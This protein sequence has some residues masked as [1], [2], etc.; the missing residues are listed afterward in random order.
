M[1][2]MKRIVPALLAAFLLTLTS[3]SGYYAYHYWR[4]TQRIEAMHARMALE[5]KP[6]LKYLVVEGCNPEGHDPTQR[7]HVDVLDARISVPCKPIRRRPY[8]NRQFFLGWSDSTVLST[9]K[10]VGYRVSYQGTYASRSEAE[11]ASKWAAPLE[12]G[13]VDLRIQTSWGAQRIVR[14]NC[15]VVGPGCRGSASITADVSALVTISLLSRETMKSL[16]TTPSTFTDAELI[17]VLNLAYSFVSPLRPKD[18]GESPRT[19]T[20]APSDAEVQP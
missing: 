5:P 6:E 3:C 19:S 20:P 1:W 17:E 2:P 14:M 10:F 8:T 9:G 4:M 18:P 11:L 13:D 7:G 15:G 16:P 12:R